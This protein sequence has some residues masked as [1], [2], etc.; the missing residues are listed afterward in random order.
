AVWRSVQDMRTCIR[1]FRQDAAT[2]NQ[3]KID[4][5]KVIVGGTSSGAYTA[6]HTAIL[7]K[8]AE[9]S[10]SKFV[11]PL[12]QTPF[13]STD[14]LGGFE[15][16]NVVPV[17]V[18]VLYPGYSSRPQLVISLG[19]AVGDTLFQEAGDPPIIA[20]HCEDD[21]TTPYGTAIVYTAVGNIPII[22]VSGS[23]DFM[24]VATQL[25]N[26]NIFNGVPTSLYPGLRTFPTGGFDCFNRSTTKLQESIAY[27]S[28]LAYRVLFDQNSTSSDKL[29]SN[30]WVECYPNPAS[31]SVQIRVKEDSNLH[32]QT[33]EIWSIDGKLVETRELDVTG[34]ELSI[35]SLSNGLYLLK[36]NTDRGTLIQKLSVQK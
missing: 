27:S 2:T 16:G 25:G 17:N 31:R 23:R 34:D 9:L 33:L 10:Y 29:L 7:D 3:W 19:G 1:Y 6:L 30:S 26:Q 24:K 15:G 22:E 4:P 21:N 35:E 18:P 36:I 20:M 13:I 12:N 11:N 32:L 8:Q 5:N 28:S 14:T